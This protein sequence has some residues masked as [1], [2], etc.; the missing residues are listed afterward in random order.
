MNVTIGINK[1]IDKAMEIVKNYFFDRKIKIDNNICSSRYF[2]NINMEN[3]KAVAHKNFYSDVAKAILDIIL[4]IYAEDII[5]KNLYLYVDD[6]KVSE[7]KEVAKIS[8]NI[9]L[10]KSNFLDEKK[11]I[12]METKDYLK[13]N[14]IILV[15][16]LIRFR[17]KQLDFLIDLAI[18][19]GIDEFTI[20]KEYKEFIKILQYFVESQEPKYELIHL[21][22]ED[23]DYK[24]LDD[25]G[26]I[27][28]KDFFS[29]IITEMDD[30]NISK[31]DI[32]ISTL[33]VLAPEKI[34]LHLDDKCKDEDVIKVI[35]NVFQDRIY[36]CQ[37]CEKCNKEIKIKS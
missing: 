8:K 22:F 19:K 26:N 29:E 37:G 35:L 4:N 24:L 20:E 27:I 31:N 6:L 12:Y 28:D 16:G 13:N 21:I 32:L 17:L 15:D 5:N 7:K 9:L 34:I 25:S 2:I 14:S 33:I 36:I 23:V 1:N 11:S 10:D 30:T 18:E 3:K